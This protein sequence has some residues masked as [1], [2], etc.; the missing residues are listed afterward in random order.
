LAIATRLSDD[1]ILFFGGLP[2]SG[3]FSS[4]ALPVAIKV[5]SV[6]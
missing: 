3:R 1:L 6:G 2:L 4:S 5:E